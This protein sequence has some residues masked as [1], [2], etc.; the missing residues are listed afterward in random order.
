MSS[1]RLRKRFKKRIINDENLIKYNKCFYVSNDAVVKRKI[2]KKHH[3]HSL[4][5]HFETQKTLNL[6]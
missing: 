1:R 6:I 2:I 3:D 4:L 5:K